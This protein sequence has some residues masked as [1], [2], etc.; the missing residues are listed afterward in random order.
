MALTDKATIKTLLGISDT[1]LDAAIDLM[2]PQAGAIIKGYLQRN[3]EQATYTEFYSGSGDK[4]L[5]LNQTPVQ[6]ITSVH[7]DSDGY[8]GDGTEAFPA[9][10]VLVEGTDFVLQKDDATNTE[11]SKSGIVYHT[12]KG[13]PRP[14]S[15]LQGQ[16]T[17]APGLGIGNIKVVYVAGWATVPSDIQFAANKLVISMVQSIDHGGR[18][19][20]ESIEDYSYT[21]AG[22]E[23]EGKFLDSVR[24][25]LAHYKKVVI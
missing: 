19:E 1:S 13:W 5:L 20:S 25:S 22:F 3:I 10:S 11:V 8:Y 23:D 24:G 15:R 2:I 16:L 18:V 12:G 21:L 9:S 7:L 14:S 4:V 17:S 6:S